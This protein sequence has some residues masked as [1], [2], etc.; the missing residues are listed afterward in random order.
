[1]QT[2]GGDQ[3]SQSHR[4]GP[5]RAK[6]LG[7]RAATMIHSGIL[8]A[9]NILSWSWS[10]SLSWGL[11]TEVA[12]CISFN[13]RFWGLYRLWEIHMQ[14]KSIKYLCKRLQMQPIDRSSAAAN[15]VWSPREG[16]EQEE[17]NLTIDQ[18]IPGSGS[19][20]VGNSGLGPINFH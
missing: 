10:L 13:L 9:E 8:W 20:R 5:E 7:D 2:R 1:M 18:R 17:P 3:S 11:A 6:Y 4:M 12:E 19:R 15:R 16:R 14:M